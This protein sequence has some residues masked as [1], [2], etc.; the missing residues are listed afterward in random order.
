M[1][2]KPVIIFPEEILE[3]CLLAKEEKLFCE[4]GAKLVDAKVAPQ[5]DGSL[6]VI[7]FDCKN[8]GLHSNSIL[9]PENLFKPGDEKKIYKDPN[10]TYA[11]LIKEFGIIVKTKNNKE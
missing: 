2:K 10:K 6:Y 1:K 11:D 8:C 5:K 3:A 9:S 4:C 7:G